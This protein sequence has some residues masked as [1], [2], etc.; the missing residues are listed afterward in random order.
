LLTEGRIP[1]HSGNKK[2]IYELNLLANYSMYKG[3][4]ATRIKVLALSEFKVNKL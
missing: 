3:E 1:V 4:F 2:Y